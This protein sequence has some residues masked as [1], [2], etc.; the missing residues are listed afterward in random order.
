MAVFKTL[1]LK[2]HL[3]T[4]YIGQ[5]RVAWI[6]SRLSCHL[7]CHTLISPTRPT[8]ENMLIGISQNKVVIP[9][10]I[11]CSEQHYRAVFLF[12]PLTD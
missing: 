9:I 3:D 4:L 8:G 5:S 12:A 10:I 2:D 11:R 1:R 7:K 6:T